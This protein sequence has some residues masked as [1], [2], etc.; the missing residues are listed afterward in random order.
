MHQP[1]I[2]Q[3]DS[4]I[5]LINFSINSYDLEWKKRKFCKP[6]K[7]GGLNLKNT[8]QFNMVLESK[9]NMMTKF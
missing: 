2:F 6:K 3:Q 9:F 4:I 1:L 5:K 8:K 7:Y